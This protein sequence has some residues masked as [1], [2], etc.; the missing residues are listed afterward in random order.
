MDQ[1]S[2]WLAIVSTSI[3]IL[4]SVA[5]IV[6]AQGRRAR[7]SRVG[8][9]FRQT[10]EDLAS[11]KRELQ[12]SAALLLRRFFDP[13]SEQGGSGLPYAREAIGV[14]AGLLRTVEDEHLRKALA[15]GLRYA[16]SLRSADLQGC[17]LSGAYLGERKCSAGPPGGRPTR[18][19]AWRRVRSMM[20]GES[21]NDG[22]V[23]IACADF[24]AAK[25]HGASLRGALA[26]T[27]VF[28]DADLTEV[29]FGGADLSGADF[30]LASLNGA[31]FTG[32]TLTGARFTSGASGIP[33]Q[34]A[35]RLDAD[36]VYK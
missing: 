29:Q 8:D 24:Y 9:A 11:G 10:V 25:L 14:I 21:P 34:I 32:A 5:G 3:T 4:I 6:A 26:Q 28:Y 35:L 12:V 13:R 1:V 30:R 23:D 17:D 31:D 27:A 22:P 18:I 16:P 19:R 7:A 20:N 36:G 15:D 2:G 33:F